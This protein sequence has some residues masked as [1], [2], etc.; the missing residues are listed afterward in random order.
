[1]TQ[2]LYIN[3]KIHMTWPGLELGSLRRLAAWA[4]ARTHQPVLVSGPHKGPGPRVIPL[5]HLRIYWC[6]MRSLVRGQ[7]CSLQ[8]LQVLPKK[9]FSDPS[10]AG[11]RYFTI[12]D[13]RFFAICQS[14]GHIMTDSK[15]AIPSWCQT[16]ICD[17][18]P[19]FLSPWDFL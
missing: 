6:G 15:S 4:T 5:R 16:P 8:I 9:S 19:I 3:H 14:Q 1:L 7:V 2:C 13:S 17:Q 12:S 18:R 10:L 11:L